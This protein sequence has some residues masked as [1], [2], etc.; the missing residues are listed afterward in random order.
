LFFCDLRDALLQNIRTRVRNGELTE[1]G[2]ARLL[3][4]SQPHMHNVLKGT[5]SISTEMSDR[6]LAQLRLSALD[7]IEIPTLRRHVSSWQDGASLCSYLP[8]LQG[9]LG[10]SQPWPSEVERHERFPVPASAVARMWHPV[11]VRL[12]ADARMQP[13]FA[14]GDLAL[15]DQAHAARTQTDP[16]AVYVLKRGAVGLVRRIRRSGQALY[17]VA[18]DSIDRPSGWERL[19]AE[20]Q[21]ITYFVRARVTF[22]TRELEWP[23]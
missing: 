23:R 22:V 11:V 8:V 18:E 20:E 10:P 14:D 7:L 15:L 12:A 5:R 9:K 4:I 16:N 19:P 3:G 1:R 2:L 6:I 13:L 17:M 21:P